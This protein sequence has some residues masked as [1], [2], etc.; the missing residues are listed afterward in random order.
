[1]W[2]EDDPAKRRANMRYMLLIYE[3]EADWASLSEAERDQMIGEYFQLTDGL[4]SSG[5]YLAGAPLQPIATATT[6]RVRNGKTVT[7]DGPFAETREQLGGYYLI[8]AKNLDE[9]LAVAARIPAARLGSIEV[10]PVLEMETAQ[11]EAAS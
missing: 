5:T 6:V 7:T 1:V 9:A 10:R 8:D 11:R 2:P 4:K 3:R